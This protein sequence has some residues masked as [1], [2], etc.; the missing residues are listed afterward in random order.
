M[1][2]TAPVGT[3]PLDGTS[4]YDYLR[5]HYPEMAE[6]VRIYYEEYHSSHIQMINDYD[7]INYLS[8]YINTILNG[9]RRVLT[10]E[11]RKMFE[12]ADNNS[13]NVLSELRRVFPW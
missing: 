4:L 5:T 9:S 3:A 12:I 7:V 10:P 11:H 8:L 2:R 1:A 13:D 6:S